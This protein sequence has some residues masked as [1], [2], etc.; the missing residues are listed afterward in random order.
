M[1]VMSHHHAAHQRQLPHP[2]ASGAPQRSSA[3]SRTRRIGRPGA[4]SL[5]FVNSPDR[6]ER[7]HEMAAR[8]ALPHET[9]A[10]K[11]A[12]LMLAMASREVSGAA[13]MYIAACIEGTE[14][15]GA[16]PSKS[17]GRGVSVSVKS[18]ARTPVHHLQGW[19][20][21][22]R[23]LASDPAVITYFVRPARVVVSIVA[24]DGSAVP[25]ATYGPDLVVLRNDE[26][27]A[28]DVQDAQV[29]V[30][31]TEEQVENFS[32][33]PAGTRGYPKPH[34]L[35]DS[36]RI[37]YERIALGQAGSVA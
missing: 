24:D 4:C 6:A 32:F 1:T 10:K 23:S 5:E 8:E 31:P 14:L 30:L 19:R 18:S 37:R 36:M 33:A 25:T 28:I 22:E 12:A 11:L 13:R 34:Q 26:V 7:D 2:A 16:T 9:D 29:E 35:F 17:S 21:I 20:E 27:V 3:H 15:R